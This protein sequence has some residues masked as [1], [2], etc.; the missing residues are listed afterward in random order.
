MLRLLR[1]AGTLFVAGTFVVALSSCRSADKGSPPDAE[2][3]LT[4]SL[5]VVGE[6]SD[7]DTDTFKLHLTPEK[8]WAID[9]QTGQHLFNSTNGTWVFAV[10]PNRGT[11]L[12][13]PNYN[14]AAFIQDLDP[15]M[16]HPGTSG[17]R[18]FAQE[19]ARTFRWHV[20]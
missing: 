16:A 1:S 7:D 4:T 17:S 9:A 6:A 12:R 19:T 2:K 18:G 11:S 3:K 15:T 20:E 10:T 13:A 8:T 14:E 5:T